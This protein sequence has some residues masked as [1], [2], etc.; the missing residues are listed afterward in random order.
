[1]IQ[2]EKISFGFPQKELFHNISFT[3]EDGCH[4]ALIGRNGVGKT[5]LVDL[6]R[7]RDE[8]LFEGTLCLEGV[9]RIGYV[10]QFVTGGREETK[11]V[12]EDLSE[13]FLRLQE[14][15]VAV[16][17]QMGESDAL[18]ALMARYQTL[19]DE[20]D[21]LDADNFEQNIRRQLALA[22]L[23]NKGTLPLSALS[24]GEQKLVQVIRQMLRRPG[25]L[26]MDEP[27]VFL[28]FDNL[29]ALRDLINAYRGT[30]L[31]VTHSR[32]LLSHCF[33]KL[34]QLENGDLQEFEGSYAAYSCS[35]LQ[36]KI[37]RKLSA[38]AD[39]EAIRLTEEMV[40]RLRDEA[41]EVAQ[42]QKGRT[43]KGKV[44]YLNRL[45]ARRIKP[46]FVEIREPMIRLPEVEASPEDVPLL[47]VEH[48]RLA[49]ED[50]L[51]EDVSFAVH[52]GEKVVLVGP[53]GTGKT[54]LLR[55]IKTR[56]GG[57]IRFSEDAHP[58]FFSQLHAEVLEETRTIYEEFYAA[59]F[60]T[61]SSVEDFLAPYCF[62]PDTLSQTVGTL[63]GGEKN[64]LQL[65]K[66]SLSG[67][68][69]LLLDEPSSHLDV[70]AQIALERALTAYRGA[71]LMVSHD[72]Y[73]VVNCADTILC[74]DEKTVRPMSARAFRKKIYKR[75]F[76]LAYLEL[77]Q[78]RSELETRIERALADGEAAL[79]QTL[80]DRL[81]EV[82]AEMAAHMRTAD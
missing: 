34:W 17:A 23:E 39:D 69:L 49:F 14:E 30:L 44:S 37:D 51:L 66:L 78:K 33:D 4:C 59:G 73:T 31:V 10:S 67:A 81:G 13:D 36:T 65:A 11:T 62:A 82:V 74:V 25:L 1:M 29:R 19:L 80:C 47:T 3:L 15:I 52:P 63:S 8:I 61:P 42:A 24:G 9:G 26:I 22:G 7:R 21:S 43:L 2:A 55:E 12:L 68:N 32:Y 71:V 53:N 48:Y 76:S 20:S 40:E 77:E 41:S 64:L 28:D 50:T 75:H 72:F 18:D 27:D 57:A 16:C 58:A 60:E 79:A 35:R 46:P 6:L 54:S 38:D 56:N 70:F 5:T 45:M